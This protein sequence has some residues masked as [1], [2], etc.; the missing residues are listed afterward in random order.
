[1]SDFDDDDDVPKLSQ[2]ALNALADFYREQ[3]ELAANEKAADWHKQFKEDWQLSQFWYD[4]ETVDRLSTEVQ[5]ASEGKGAIALISCPTLYGEIRRKCP[6]CEVKLLEFDRRFEVLGDD[7]NFYNY[8]TPLEL[9]QS[10]ANHF[11]LV[12]ADPPFLSEECLTKTA[13]TMR[14]LSNS[15]LI[16]CTGT[17]MEELAVRLLGV[18]KT[19][20]NP[21]HKNNLSNEFSCFTNYDDHFSKAGK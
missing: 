5:S 17:I 16:L 21:R 12:I 1:M 9:P 3:N 7:Y 4:E 8:E 6:N 10:F 14:F 18:K 19:P 15:K 2:E 11:D 13:V 20:F